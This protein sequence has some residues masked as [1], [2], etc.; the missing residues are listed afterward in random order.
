MDFGSE[1][2]LRRRRMA[3]RAREPTLRCISRKWRV[4]MCAV[5]VY[6]M[7]LNIISNSALIVCIH[8]LLA[9]REHSGNVV[10]LLVLTIDKMPTYATMMVEIH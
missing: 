6:Q 2:R 5:C 9:N 8:S 3:G 7:D 10:M 1:R 4:R